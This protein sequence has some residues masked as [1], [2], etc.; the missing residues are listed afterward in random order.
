MSNSF[1][2]IICPLLG[3]LMVAAVAHAGGVDPG[4]M[5]PQKP[6]TSEKVSA[7]PAQTSTA[8]SKVRRAVAPAVKEVPMRSVS[9]KTVVSA[10][11]APISASKDKW[12]LGS[13]EGGC[14]PLESVHR[15][16]K[17]IGSFK[18]PHEF[19][20]QMQ[21]RGYQ[22]FVLDIGDERDQMMRVKVPDLDLN[23]TFMKTGMCR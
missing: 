6:V 23:L 8:V 2:R 21:Q 19:A 5:P 3:L 16:V 4:D 7:T 10:S 14:T 18:T 9:P 1:I 15:K 22:A 13:R 20:H 11:K 12:L 17:N